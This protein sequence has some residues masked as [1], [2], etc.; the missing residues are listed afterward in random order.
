MAQKS[1]TRAMARFAA[2]RPWTVITAW[3][4]LLV[5][6]IAAASA[7]A[8][9]LSTGM[10]MRVETESSRAEKLLEERLRGPQEVR[11]FV[12]IRSDHGTVL[13]EDFRDRA[14]RLLAEIVATPGVVMALN[15]YESLD[16]ALLSDDQAT[17]L[18]PVVLS[19]TVDEAAETVQPLMALL[20]RYDGRDGFSVVTGGEG[21]ISRAFTETAEKDL[22]ML[23]AG[24]QAS[25]RLSSRKATV[26]HLPRNRSVLR[27]SLAK[28]WRRP[29][30][31]QMSQ[32][33]GFGCRM[34]LPAQP[35]LPMPSRS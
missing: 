15:Y 27:A 23:A 33:T 4:L 9:Q 31:H 24:T 5:A 13:D 16:S 20:E 11:E 3:A 34:R 8:G 10:E 26:S 21:S 2:R 12:L 17:L 18:I 6:G 30:S 25:I 29:A 35:P 1:I 32:R 19:G 7:M 14:G 28:A 22:R